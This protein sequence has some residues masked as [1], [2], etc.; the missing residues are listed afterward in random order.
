MLLFPISS[1]LLIS[2]IPTVHTHPC[3]VFKLL[4]TTQDMRHLEL[5]SLNHQK[6]PSF[7]GDVKPYRRFTP[8]HV[9]CSQFGK[10]RVI[11]TDCSQ[12]T[13]ILLLRL[14]DLMHSLLGLAWAFRRIL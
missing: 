14:L 9:N 13:P 4:T 1:V 11:A 5:G 12:Y 10:C 3:M 6:T 7:G 2:F 8:V